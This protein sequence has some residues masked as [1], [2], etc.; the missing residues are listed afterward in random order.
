[1][2]TLHVVLSLLLSS[3]SGSA[4]PAG[5]GA[6]QPGQPGADGGTSP[7]AGTSSDLDQYVLARMQ[8]ARIPGLAAVAVKTDH[9]VFAGA[10]GEAD[11]SVHR[12]ITTDTL[13]MLGSISKTV[14]AVALMQ[15]YELGKFKLDDR[16]E[17]HTS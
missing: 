15:L 16:S 9:T 11:L 10:W 2:R 14:T 6:P 8:T 13:F 5:A 7:D 3:C 4:T 12:P 1:M 17:E